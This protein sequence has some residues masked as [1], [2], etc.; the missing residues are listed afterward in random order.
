MEGWHSLAGSRISRAEAIAHELELEITGG[1]RRPGDRLGTKDDLRQRF[2]VA[3]ATIN[4]AIR[5][6]EMRRYVEAR[7]GPGG[8]IFVAASSTRVR[9]GN[10]ILGFKWGSASY[11]DCM[12]VRNALEPSVCCDAARHRRPDDVR[13]LQKIL[14]DME[15]HLDSPLDY[16]RLDWALHR[17][18]ARVCRNAPLQGFY[19]LVL[20]SLEEA[21]DTVEAG[22]FVEVGNLA[23]HREL[24]SAIAMGDEVGAGGRDLPPPRAVLADRVG[25]GGGR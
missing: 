25:A 9:L 7:P 21:L 13:A 17:R 2:G 11:A 8:G 1:R 3:V 10:L 5:L 15:Q 20:D 4:E 6:L 18:I 23:G 14:A 12:D 24:V 19:L 16:I 22:D